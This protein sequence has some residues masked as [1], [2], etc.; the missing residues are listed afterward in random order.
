TLQLRGCDDYVRSAIAVDVTD[1][2]KCV[3]MRP[4]TG[5]FVLQPRVLAREVPGVLVPLVVDHDVEPAIV[6]DIGGH[7]SLPIWNRDT[8]PRPVPARTLMEEEEVST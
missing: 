6:I 8:I 5:V 7:K 1:V 2:Q 4:L 3:F